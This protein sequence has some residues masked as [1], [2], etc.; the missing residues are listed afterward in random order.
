MRD[1]PFDALF[2]D[3][4]GTVCAGDRAA[5]EAAC[6]RIV[7]ALSLPLSGSEFAIRWGE[8]FFDTVDRSNHAAFKTLHA[9]E[10]SSLRETLATFGVEVDPA[11][12][13][14]PI[15]AYWVNPPLHDDV[16]S[17][18]NAINLPTCCVSN[19]DDVPLA[20]AVRKHRLAFDRVVSSERARCY[21][22]DPGIFRIAAAEMGVRLDRV[23]HVGDSLHS[24]IAGAAAAGTPPRHRPG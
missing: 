1:G 18:L 5:V 4:Y 9:C 10:L 2:I 15:E 11:P 17:F 7:E 20:T 21:K 23:V 6:D 22:P 12:F 13:V 19:A 8:R 24:D 16:L 3:F 14:A